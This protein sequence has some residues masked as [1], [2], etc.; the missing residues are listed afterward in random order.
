[1]NSVILCEMSPW[2]HRGP[3]IDPIYLEYQRQDIA[4]LNSKCQDYVYVKGEYHSTMWK[5]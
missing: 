4:E 3:N 2:L 1:M 5:K